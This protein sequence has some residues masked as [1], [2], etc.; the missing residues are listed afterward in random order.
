MQP[1]CSRQVG[2]SSTGCLLHVPAHSNKRMQLSRVHE[3]GHSIKNAKEVVQ[4][5]FLGHFRLY[6]VVIIQWPASESEKKKQCGDRQLVTRCT[7]LFVRPSSIL[8]T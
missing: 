2:F 5:V 8:E 7:A 4:Q 3:G 1:A 6:G